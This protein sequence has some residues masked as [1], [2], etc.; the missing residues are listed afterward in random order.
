MKNIFV[1]M[2]T[3]VCALLF[4]QT[5]DF[6]ED[7]LFYLEQQSQ[8]KTQSIRTEYNQQQLIEKNKLLNNL[9]TSDVFS[10]PSFSLYNTDSYNY[11]FNYSIETFNSESAN[12]PF[13]ITNIINISDDFYNSIPETIIL[14]EQKLNF[15]LDEYEKIFEKIGLNYSNNQ[16][17]LFSNLK[18][19]LSLTSIANIPL[20]SYQKEVD[21][22][23][24]SVKFNDKNQWWVKRIIKDRYVFYSQQCADF[25]SE[26]WEKWRKI[27]DSKPE[28]VKKIGYQVPKN[29]R[30]MFQVWTPQNCK[31]KDNLMEQLDFIKQKG[32]I[33]VVV[34]WDGKSDYNQ[35]VKLQKEIKEKGFR[36]WLG[37]SPYMGQLDVQRKDKNGKNIKVNEISMSTFVQPDYYKEGLKALAV[38]SQAFLMGWRRTSIHVNFQNQQ[39]QNY[40]MQALRSGNPKIGFIGQFY[41]GEVAGRKVGTYVNYKTNY[42][43]VLLVNYGYISINP[44]KTIKY[45]R[46]IIGYQPKLVCLIQGVR[47]G[48]VTLSSASN[49]KR[50]RNIS[51]HRRINEILQ[52]RF[53]KAGFDAVCGLAGDGFNS[54]IYPDNM[55]KSNI[56]KPLNTTKF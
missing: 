43:A 36:I 49:I 37:F 1:L 47:P 33:G 50:K 42:D 41:Y 45:V 39:W 9:N 15:I 22:N 34:M 54:W 31:E 24:L 51:Q 11:N 10:V 29:G 30:F 46:S 2:I 56:R 40:T 44:S 27:F 16:Q 26:L 18:Q 8:Q 23:Y 20:L 55:C 32:Y 6:M 38:N 7:Y 25:D 35:L 14:S 19:Y 52:K 13:N 3:L 4:A 28:A 48:Y 17:Y 5:N 53:L 21:V 12:I